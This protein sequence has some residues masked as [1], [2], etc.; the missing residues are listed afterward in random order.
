[1]S[2]TY[3]V[4]R[5]IFNWED[6][7]RNEVFTTV[8]KEVDRLQGRRRRK[9]WEWRTIPTKTVAERYLTQ[10]VQKLPELDGRIEVTEMMF[11]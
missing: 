9:P 8:N 1:M 4:I 5:P 3:Y 7:D 6:K 2:K 11:W 10:I